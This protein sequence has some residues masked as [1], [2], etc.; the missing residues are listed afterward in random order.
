MAD[1]RQSI[2]LQGFGVT[3]DAV[4]PPPVPTGEIGTAAARMAAFLDPWPVVMPDGLIDADDRAALLGQYD[5]GMGGSVPLM[6]ALVV[7]QTGG[8]VES[9]TGLTGGTV[10]S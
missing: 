10:E 5:P 2:I 4:E 8:R 9:D 7:N 3:A 6:G 1:L